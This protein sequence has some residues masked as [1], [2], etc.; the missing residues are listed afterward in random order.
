MPCVIADV[1]IVLG[2]TFDP[3]HLGHVSAA[4]IVS[5]SL[6]NAPVRMMLAGKPRLRTEL[7]ASTRH[8]WHMLELACR[9]Q[10]TL[11]PDDTELASMHE[12][13]TASTVE[14]LGGAPDKPVIW[15]LGD[16]AAVGM[17]S[18]IRYQSLR[19]MTSLYVLTRNNVRLDSIR[20]DF[21]EVFNPNELSNAGG[22]IYVCNEPVPD[23][24]ATSIRNSL[25]R[26]ESVERWLH[27]AVFAYIIEEHLY[28]A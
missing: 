24:S 10:S 7:P 19:E 16:D 6:G 9:E 17:Q 4:N 11:V 14:S 26:G 25:M 3:V 12:T 5:E 13:Q 1:P 27:P 8:R 15:V 23:I 2:G 18:W 20:K 28:Q 22:R 21:I